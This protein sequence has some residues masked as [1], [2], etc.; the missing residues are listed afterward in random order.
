MDWDPVGGYEFGY[1]VPDPL[2]PNL[3]YA[4]SPSRGV[5]RI[6]RTNRQ[7]YNVSPSVVPGNTLATAAQQWNELMKTDLANL[8]LELEK[9]KIGAAPASMLP[10]PSCTR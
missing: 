7:V 2:N 5:V 6:D 3:V 8:N 10:V 1:I 4:G 9:Q